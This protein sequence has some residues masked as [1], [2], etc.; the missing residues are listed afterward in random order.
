MF[1]LHQTPF[2]SSQ[3]DPRMG[4]H[5]YKTVVTAINVS[6]RMNAQVCSIMPCASEITTRMG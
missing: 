2:C 6:G 4:T 3:S 1:C 5:A